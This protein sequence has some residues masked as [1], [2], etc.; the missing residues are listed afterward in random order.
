MSDF[1]F[2]LCHDPHQFD[3][4]PFQSLIGHRSHRKHIGPRI[5][6]E[7]CP[8]Q[9]RYSFIPH[10]PLKNYLEKHCEGFV[11]DPEEKYTINYI[12]FV[13][14]ANWKARELFSKEQDS[15]LATSY[16]KRAFMTT[17]KVIGIRGLRRRVASQLDAKAE[18][19][20]M[21]I[22]PNSYLV[23]LWCLTNE[24]IEYLGTIL[25]QSMFD[26]FLKFYTHI[27]DQPGSEPTGNSNT[28]E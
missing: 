27:C 21:R 9:E 2:S 1:K 4:L 18:D 17:S 20:Y 13:L 22:D 6:Y 3:H 15:V 8:H 14:L 12:V 19:F 23:P 26:M 11:Q 28:S 7:A 24:D 10:S 16:I 5:H 25:G